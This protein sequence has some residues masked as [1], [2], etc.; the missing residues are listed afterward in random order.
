MFTKL[1]K[2]SVS[3]VMSVCVCPFVCL[4]QTAPTVWLFVKMGI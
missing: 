4:E 3:F 1:R 2:A